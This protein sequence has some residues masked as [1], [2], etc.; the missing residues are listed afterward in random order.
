VLDGADVT[1]VAPHRRARLGLG[2]TFQRIEV[3]SSLTPP[4]Q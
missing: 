2:R 4:F 3:F 1:G